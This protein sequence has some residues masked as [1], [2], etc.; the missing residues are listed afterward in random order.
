VSHDEVSTSKDGQ[1]QYSHEIRMLEK[2][3][4]EWKLVGQSIHAYVPE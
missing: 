3:A 2:V 4:G 1:K